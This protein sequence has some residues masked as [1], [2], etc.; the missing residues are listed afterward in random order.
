[1]LAWRP[2]PFAFSKPFE[3]AQHPLVLRSE[4]AERPRHEQAD[5]PARR[6]LQNS[7][8]MNGI[9]AGRERVEQPNT[10]GSKDARL[11]RHWLLEIQ[12]RWW[13]VSRNPAMADAHRT[14]LDV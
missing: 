5:R 4:R 7:Q 9:R 2:T 6:K 14:L 13:L 12:L 3:R 11:H 8:E 10:D 1:M